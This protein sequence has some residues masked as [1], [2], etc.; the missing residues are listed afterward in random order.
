VAYVAAT[1]ARDLLVVPAV[2]DVEYDGGWTA[3]MNGAIYPPVHSRRIATPAPGAPAFKSDSV[4]RRPDNDPAT[5]TTICPGLHVQESDEGPYPIVW[6]D[7]FALELGVETGVGLRR[8]SLITKDVPEALVADGRREYE[9]WRTQREDAIAKG[10]VASIAVRTATEWSMD[11]ASQMP[12]ASAEPPAMQAGLFDESPSPAAATIPEPTAD[13]L[14]VDARG[15]RRPGGARFGE[16]V[17]AIL[18]SAALE[19]DHDAVA[20][21]ADVQGRIL[22]APD[23]EVAAAIDTVQRVLAHDL[24]GRARR[25]AARGACRRETPVTCLLDAGV[26]VEGIVDL[27]FEERGAWTVVDYKS[28]RELAAIGEERYRRQVAL[29]ASAIAQ[30][31]GLPTT[32]VL[33]RV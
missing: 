25:A 31:T 17:H 16:L 4:W 3:P 15:P 13:V 24:L 10:S 27:A 11:A 26:L 28:D 2:G 14:I 1:R 7:P 33:I 21:A 22:A 18:A 6:W 30:A 9:K 29:Y 23:E 8:E 19:A 32:G 20:A 12:V 5:S